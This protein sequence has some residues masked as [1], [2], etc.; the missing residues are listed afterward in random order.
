VIVVLI[1]PTPAPATTLEQLSIEQLSRRAA[2]VF[3][4]TVVSMAVEQTSGGVRT[5]VRVRVKDSLKGVPSTFKTVYVPGGTL[6]DGSQVVVDAMAVF[7]PG[8]ACYVFVDT[9]GWVMGGFQGKLD[10][11][12]G[13]VLG[14]GVT[15]ATMSRRIE[16]ALRA[17]KP[18]ARPAFATPRTERPGTP[19]QGLENGFWGQVRGISGGSAVPLS[20]A[21]VELRLDGGTEVP[22]S[23]TTDANGDYRLAAPYRT[24]YGYIMR[25]SKSGYVTYE[26][27]SI[28]PSGWEKRSVDLDAIPSTAPIITAITPGHAS[29]GT[30]THVTITGTRFGSA[31]GKV[32]FSYGRDSVMRISASDISSWTNTSINCAVPTALI[33]NYD[34]S[35][36]SGPVVV[37]TSLS[38]ESNAYDFVVPFG[39]GGHKWA[40]GWL[41]IGAT[42]FVNTSGIDDARRLSLVD[43]GAAAWNAAGSEFT[44]ED[45]ETTTLGNAEDDTNVISWARGLPAGVL[46][47]AASY[48]DASGSITEAD[49]QF[50]N[51]YS[52]GD[53]VV[54]SGTYDIQTIAMHELGHWLELLDQYMP[55][56]SGKAMYGYG[57]ENKQKRTLA[58]GDLAGITWVYPA[59]SV[60]PVCAAR[61]ATVKRG[62]T[63]KLY[64]KVHDALSKKVT[65]Q[66][67]VATR[68]GAVKQKWARGYGENFAGWWLV[69]Y[70]CKLPRGTYSIQASGKDLAGNSASKV[71]RATLTVK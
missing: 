8:E 64:F 50:N 60:G 47:Q 56:D 2:M 32:E 71:G 44:F 28:D 15:T 43:A 4:G 9:L 40:A 24:P 39:Y 30:D 53:G 17:A 66:L 37:T 68:S 26:S 29:A 55:G 25:V 11:V 10:V 7:R 22:Y 58:A 35:A 52:W 27:E 19:V 65:M 13:R 62:S 63:V 38:E 34:A 31:R 45:G 21:L 42:Y 41:S 12:A 33:S 59:D 67:V 36:G 61:S 18:A 5:A 51:A 69:S 49:I 14:S 46:A 1:W 70:K 6:P 20:G 3:E 16:A 54:G 57:G 48:R 23:T